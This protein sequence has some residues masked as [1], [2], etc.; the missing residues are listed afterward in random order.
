[1]PDVAGMVKGAIPNPLQQQN[2]IGGMLQGILG[3][4]K[5]TEE[6]AKP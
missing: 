5:K 2:G 4:K 1:M 3:G 6:P